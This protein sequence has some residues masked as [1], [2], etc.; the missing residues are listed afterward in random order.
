MV[1][2]PLCNSWI[3]VEGGR[4]KAIG[5]SNDYLHSGID[6]GSVAVIPGLV[7]AHTHLELSHLSGRVPQSGHFI[8][9]VRS[10][11]LNRNKFHD[12]DNLNIEQAAVNGIREAKASGTALVGDISNTLLTVKL[13]H[14]ASLGGVVF[15]ELLGFDMTKVKPFVREARKKIDALSVFSDIR[16]SLAPHAPY[17][18]SAEMFREIRRD[19]DAHPEV[20]TSVHLGES[21]EELEFI[22]F[23]TGAWREELKILGVWTNAWK[24]AGET[25]VE[26]LVNLGFLD[27]QVLVVHGVHFR[28][29]D[30]SQLAR[31]GISIVTCPRSNRYVGV[32]SPP[33]ENF[34]KAGLNVAIGTDSLASASDLN[35]FSELFEARRI[36]PSVPARTLLQSATINGARA[37]GFGKDYGSIEPGKRASLVTVDMPPNEENV[38][39]YLLSGIQ[40]SDVNWIEAEI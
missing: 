28:E 9:W 8:G 26:Y 39:E 31:L 17:S 40:P 4:I 24:A 16:I 35:I 18:V 38:E 25:P 7:N 5:K 30:L 3:T 6:L 37:L 32:G 20:V 21:A 15:H 2:A 19:L 36:A 13:M 33:L 27:R 22:A 12:Q 1:G 23:G 29:F 34:Y 10:L 14:E 11:I